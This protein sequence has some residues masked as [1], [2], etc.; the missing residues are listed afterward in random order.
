MKDIDRCKSLLRKKVYWIRLDKNVADFIKSC[1]PCQ[2]NPR[3][4]PPTPIRMSKLPNSPWEEIAIDL[5]GRLPT[6]NSLFIIID[7][8][9]RYPLIEI[10]KSTK[11]KQ[12]INRW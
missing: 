3:E 1:I 5:C 9:S 12:V 6:G 7:R 8:Y 2:A 10:I 11:A 4:N